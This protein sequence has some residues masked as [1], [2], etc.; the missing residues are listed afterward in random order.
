MCAD[1]ALCF[2]MAHS[3]LAFLNFTRF[4]SLLPHM[5]CAFVLQYERKL[6]TASAQQ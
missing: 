2:P 4:L 1:G 3:D 5:P 6:T